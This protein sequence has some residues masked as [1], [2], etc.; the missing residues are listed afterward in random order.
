MIHQER[1][2]VHPLIIIVL[3]YM[4]K[5]HNKNYRDLIIKY[6]WDI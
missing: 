4:F 3:H 2:V 6:H 1:L 5:H